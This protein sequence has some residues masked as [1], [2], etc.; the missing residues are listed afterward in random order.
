MQPLWCMGAPPSLLIFC[1]FSLSLKIMDL[2]LEQVRLPPGP[3]PRAGRR[4]ERLLSHGRGERFLKGPIPHVWLCAAAQLPGRA[5][6]VGVYLWFLAGMKKART[7]TLPLARLRE[8]GLDRFAVRRGLQALQKAGLVSTVTRQGRSA[9][10]TIEA[11]RAQPVSATASG[12]EQ[13]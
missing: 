1:L 9:V 2:D 6:Q 5:L 10:V 4:P 7:V 11:V 8:F 3:D 12:T 13:Q